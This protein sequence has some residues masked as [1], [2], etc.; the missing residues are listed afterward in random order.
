MEVGNP[1][2]LKTGRHHRYRMLLSWLA[3]PR[4]TAKT[5]RSALPLEAG[6][7]VDPNRPLQP[8]YLLIEEAAGRVV[9]QR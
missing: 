3:M 4:L 9:V 2:I 6:S 7:F 5:A 1:S 8:P